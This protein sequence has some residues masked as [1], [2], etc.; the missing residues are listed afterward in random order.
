MNTPLTAAPRHAPVARAGSINDRSIGARPTERAEDPN[1]YGGHTVPDCPPQYPKVAQIPVLVRELLNLVGAEKQKCE[2]VN[3]GQRRGAEPFLSVG[4]NDSGSMT[5]LRGEGVEE[6]GS[7]YGV[8][9]RDRGSRLNTRK[10][11][12]CL[13][14]CLSARRGKEY[15]SSNHL[16]R[17]FMNARRLTDRAQA[18]GDSLAGARVWDEVRAL[19]GA[20][21][22]RFP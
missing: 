11:T 16:Q 15:S 5:I 22:L 8:P 7:D 20:T 2:R 1:A 10:T 18:A 12:E 19:L 4:D 14:Q 6:D 9:D 13:R 17:G 3:M 21:T